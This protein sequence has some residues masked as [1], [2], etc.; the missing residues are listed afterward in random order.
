[1]QII[2]EKIRRT[3]GR[4]LAHRYNP[5]RCKYVMEIREFLVE[6]PEEIQCNPRR[7]TIE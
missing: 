5:E 1:M 2:R 4:D 3:F 7:S 6:R